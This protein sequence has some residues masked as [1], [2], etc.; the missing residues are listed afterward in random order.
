MADGDGAGV[1]GVAR[2]W[3]VRGVRGVV[4]MSPAGPRTGLPPGTLATGGPGVTVSCSTTR[5]PSKATVTASAVL[6]AHAATYVTDRRTC[7]ML[8]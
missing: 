3:G 4:A 5:A 7:Y 1:R 6:P 8:P 2:V